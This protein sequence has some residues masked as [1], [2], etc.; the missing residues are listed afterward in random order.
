MLSRNKGGLSFGDNRISYQKSKVKSYL[1]VFNNI[2]SE[3]FRNIMINSVKIEKGSPWRQKL[4]V[5]ICAFVRTIQA[6]T[7]PW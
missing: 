4:S 1:S 5:F 7:V 2:K 3:S 6:E